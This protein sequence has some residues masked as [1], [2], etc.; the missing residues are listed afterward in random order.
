M[1]KNISIDW[2]FNRDFWWESMYFQPYF[3]NLNNARNAK[4]IF[5]RGTHK[6]NAT[7]RKV[8]GSIPDGVMGIFQWHNP[9]GR[10]M[11]LGWT[12]PLT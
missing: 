4:I 10:T 12:Q 11:A 1:C 8:A 2:Y 3:M 9:A 6:D 7:N 5:S